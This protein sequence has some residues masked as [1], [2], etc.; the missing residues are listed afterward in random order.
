M[1]TMSLSQ[2]N[3]A[4]ALGTGQELR[5]WPRVAAG[6]MFSQPRSNRGAGDRDAR[7]RA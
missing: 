7:V 3:A 6:Q 1:L 2:I 4:R 5:F